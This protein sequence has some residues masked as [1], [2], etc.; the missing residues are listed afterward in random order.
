MK[1]KV[2]VQDIDGR[3]WEKEGDIGM[4]AMAVVK[5]GK[6]SDTEIDFSSMKPTDLIYFLAT[7]LLVASQTADIISEEAIRLYRERK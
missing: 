1:A 7:A 6:M 3:V 4:G 5:D 2:T